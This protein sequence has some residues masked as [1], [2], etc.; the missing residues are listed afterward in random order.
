[1]GIGS[2]L[3]LKW[4]FPIKSPTLT[5]SSST[6]TTTTRPCFSS[7][8]GKESSCETAILPILLSVG[9]EENDATPRE[10]LQPNTYL[11]G[12]L[13]TLG[14][15]SVDIED[16]MKLCKPLHYTAEDIPNNV[17]DNTFTSYPYTQVNG[18]SRYG[19]L[20]E[21]IRKIEEIV[22][23]KDFIRLE[24]DILTQIGTL[25]ALKLFHVCLSRTLKTPSFVPMPITVTDLP[26]VRARDDAATDRAGRIIVRSRRK[27]ERKSRR[28][29]ALE[30]ATKIYG[31]SAIKMISKVPKRASY[32]RLKDSSSSRS[33]RLVIARNESKMSK[34]IQD[35]TYLER[36]KMT[37][38]EERGRVASVSNWAEAAGVDEKE[39]QQRLH[40]GWSC[41]DKLLRSTRSLIMFL[42]R[43]YQRMGIPLEDLL[44]AGK[45]GVL[46][47]SQRFDDTRGYQFSTYVQYWIRK[48]MSKLV[49]QHSRGIQIPINVNRTI[50]QVQKARKALYGLNR[51][52]PDEMEI[53]RFTGLSLAKI[54][55]AS[56]CPRIVGSIDKKVG[57]GSLKFMDFTPDA[58][59]KTPEEVVMRQHMEQ[60]IFE[61]LQ[62]LNP[63]ERQ[64]LILRHGLWDGH[65]KSLAEI[66][67]IF[68]CTKE[69]IRKIE[70]SALTKVRTK[71]MKRS[72]S[73]Y[74][75]M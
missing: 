36:I 32:S 61:L 50:N 6:T 74:L 49:A 43:N 40:F 31:L 42:A 63:R 60:G 37:L 19:L 51:K 5:N 1:M 8:R 38:E 14:N 47:G 71:D 3:D 7:V 33:K 45:L 56:N 23:D 64:V 65:C 57:Y 28:K 66:G 24:R 55:S 62:G 18:K 16:E 48:A 12:S 73:H 2:M 17:Q 4:A 15:S 70:K 72:L 27:E 30:K 68:R 13:R 20:M 21:N 59:I 41:R 54:R 22:A 34:G 44:Q 39:L 52:H 26:S 75:I 46:Q 69:W 67:R 58:S 10:P 35:L 29:R 9:S 11:F 53:S 25:G